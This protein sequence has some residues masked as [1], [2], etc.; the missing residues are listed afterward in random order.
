[1]QNSEVDFS[2]C[3]AYLRE[4]KEITDKLASIGAEV[5]EEDQV[6]TLL[7]SLPPSFSGLVTALEARENVTLD[8]VQQSLV[9]EEIK[10]KAASGG[11][12]PSQQ[13]SALF[14]AAKDQFRK[15]PICWKC[16]EIGHIWRFC[17]HDKGKKSAPRPGHK[18]KAAQEVNS[19]DEPT[20][21]CDSDAD[22]DADL[23]VFVA[24]N[25]TPQNEKWLVDSGASSHMT[26]QLE[27]LSNYHLQRGLV[28]VTGELLMLLVWELC[29]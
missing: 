18:A 24:G 17:P 22:S 14:G 8:Y 6:V 12:T 26:A 25:G 1:M 4:M 23:G 13:D 27:Y 3:G 16:N 19:P 5:A 10:R 29:H 2:R 21:G 20:Q 9:Q 15:P 28:L 7:G 11:A